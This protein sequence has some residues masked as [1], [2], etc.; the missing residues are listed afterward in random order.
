MAFTKK[1]IKTPK[2][3]VKFELEFELS[4]LPID[5]I[6]DRVQW[7]MTSPTTHSINGLIVD[8]LRETRS[9]SWDIKGLEVEEV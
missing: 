3:K 6:R 1:E 7:T 4:S 8:L 2:F 5:D 9:S